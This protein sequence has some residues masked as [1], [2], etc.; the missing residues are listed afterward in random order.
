MRN[1][2]YCNYRSSF[3]VSRYYLKGPELDT[4]TGGTLTLHCNLFVDNLWKSESV[5][6]DSNSVDGGDGDRQ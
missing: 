4:T 5:V 1:I 3:S 6:D 2:C